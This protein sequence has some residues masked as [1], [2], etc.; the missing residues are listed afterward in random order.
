M[1]DEKTK[2]PEPLSGT[3][4]MKNQCEATFTFN[5]ELPNKPYLTFRCM[6]E[7]HDDGKHEHVGMSGSG[8]EYRVAWDEP[9]HAQL[10]AAEELF[11]GKESKEVQ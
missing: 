2:K 1:D 4:G 3:P 9:V 8:W 6:R 7:K 11:R 10:K 5:I